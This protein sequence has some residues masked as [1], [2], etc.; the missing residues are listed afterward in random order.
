MKASVP[1]CAQIPDGV[2][3]ML[4][5][6]ATAVHCLFVFQFHCYALCLHNACTTVTWKYEMHG[7][8]EIHGLW[9]KQ[10]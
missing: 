3:T 9:C 2:F 5:E 6:A 10:K 1:R 7:L 4:F 8:D